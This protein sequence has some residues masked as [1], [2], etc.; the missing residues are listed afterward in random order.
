[1]GAGTRPLVLKTSSTGGDIVFTTMSTV[2]RV[3]IISNT[4]YVGIGTD[5]PAAALDL[6]SAPLSGEPILSVTN[7]GFAAPSAIFMGGAVGIGTISPAAGLEVQ[8][9]DAALPALKTTA[10]GAGPAAVFMGNVGVGT[11]N[12][13]FLGS[14]LNLHVY[15]TGASVTSV[16]ECADATSGSALMLGPTSGVGG[17]WLGYTKGDPG[18]DWQNAFT[19]NYGSL[20]TIGSPLAIG[21]ASSSVVF[22]TSPSGLPALERMR[23]TSGGSVGIGTTNP[24]KA[25]H[26]DGSSTGTGVT[27][28]VN[29]RAIG[30]ASSIQLTAGAFG[31]T[32]V[33]LQASDSGD[34]GILSSPAA[35]GLQFITH[36][37]ERMRITYGGNVGIGTTDPIFYSYS[38][39]IRLHIRADSTTSVLIDAKDATTVSQLMVMNT[40][41][42][43][44]QGVFLSHT[45]GNPGGDWQ[46][47]FTQ[48]YSSLHSFLA[49]LAIGTDSAAPIAFF[50]G[51]VYPSSEKMRIDSNGNVGI[52][53]TSPVALL[54]MNGS[55]A[56]NVDFKL[57]NESTGAARIDMTTAYGGGN[58]VII[59]AYTDYGF[60]TTKGAGGLHLQAANNSGLSPILLLTVDPGTLLSTER[61]RITS[62]GSVGIGTTIPIYKFE[63]DGSSSGNIT[64][65]VHNAAPEGAAFVAAAAD[66]TVSLIAYDN[67]TSNYGALQSF[68]LNG[69]ILKTT[70]SSTGDIAFYTKASQERMRITPGG[71]VGI[72]TTDPTSTLHN[73]GSYAGAYREVT[74]DTTLSA[75]DQFV[76]DMGT[77]GYN[78]TL[79]IAATCKG[80]MYTIRSFASSSDVLIP[81][82]PGGAPDTIERIYTRIA[83]P[84]LTK[85]SVQ[86][87]S[88]GVSNWWIMSYSPDISSIPSV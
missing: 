67:G 54:Q 40:T 63:V 11:T 10:L 88:D 60:L 32:S 7:L 87:I 20:Y 73:K 9:T 21:A 74:S 41:G 26:V 1:L 83:L 19:S 59:G 55:S 18:G 43:M 4:G 48:E 8:Y 27:V 61:M 85:S 81:V 14:P 12:P 28:L 70:N 24:S 16:V 17:L 37:S 49:P 68:A 72:G 62:G 15:G 53:T 80:R 44:P 71:N 51:D 46:T 82:N 76:I 36:T 58:E 79:P 77:G 2:E 5:A 56:G 38:I 25:L 52:G 45:S 78:I 42:L 35:N 29:N 30:Y 23:I 84:Y 75:T 47:T 13:T 33:Q 31:A 69:L 86:L 39:P 6:Q 34:A 50:T 65:F 64:A 57:V 3:R 22:A 66:T